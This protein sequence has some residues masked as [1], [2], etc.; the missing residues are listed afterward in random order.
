MSFVKSVP[1]DVDTSRVTIVPRS[2]TPTIGI[3]AAVVALAFAIPMV[4]GVWDRLLSVGMDRPTPT[5]TAGQRLLAP[6]TLAPFDPSFQFLATQ[7]GRSAPVAFDPC[8]PIR[9]VSRPD[10]APPDADE[11]VSDAINRISTASGLRFVDAGTTTEA[12]TDARA[13]YQP[14]RYGDQWAPVLIAWSDP[15]EYPDLAGSVIGEAST[16]PVEVDDGSLVLVS[17]QV[18]LDADQIAARLKYVGGRDEAVAAITHELGHL[19]GLG[20]VEDRRQLMYPSAQP[21]VTRLGAGDVSGLAELGAGRC[22][23]DL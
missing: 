23:D 8:R 21:L 9:Y 22:F 17:G 5:T 10:G 16:Q 12:P 6:L 3:R 13:N 7:P 1:T 15:L 2:S 19:V 14:D 4:F 20:H 18:V 11:M